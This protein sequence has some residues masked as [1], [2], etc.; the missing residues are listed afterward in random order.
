MKKNQLFFFFFF[1]LFLFFN[2]IAFRW[3]KLFF[4]QQKCHRLSIKFSI[5]ILPIEAAKMEGQEVKVIMKMLF[6]MENQTMANKIH[7]NQVKVWP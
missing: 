6:Q 5:E 4:V 3:I 2:S 1:F 7:Q